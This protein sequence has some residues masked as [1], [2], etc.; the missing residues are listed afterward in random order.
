MPEMDESELPQA[1]RVR[2][3]IGTPSRLEGRARRRLQLQEISPRHISLRQVK[4]SPMRWAIRKSMTVLKLARQTGKQSAV[5]TP[6]RAGMPTEWTLD[7]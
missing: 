2:L 7:G 4:D 1:K 3:D 6:L 5:R